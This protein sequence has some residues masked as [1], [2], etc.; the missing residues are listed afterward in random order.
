MFRGKPFAS[1][2]EISDDLSGEVSDAAISAL[3]HA[4]YKR[5]HIH[6]TKETMVEAV[7]VA[8]RAHKVDP[9]LD[10][11]AALPAWDGKPRIDMLFV[12][13]L[14][15][16]DTPL[17]RAFGRKFMC[18]KVRRAKQPGC[19][20]DHIAVLEGKQGKRKSMFCEDLSVAPDLFTDTSVLAGT[21][22]EQMEV[23]AELWETLASRLSKAIR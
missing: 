4:V 1:G 9:V 16:E 13:Y 3:R 10:Y 2:A 12:K 23:M 11:Y 6:P 14:G 19:K 15:A 17:N 22:K 7:R 18:A 8:C 21:A 20:W 5:F